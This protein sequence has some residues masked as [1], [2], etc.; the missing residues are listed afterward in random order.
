[1]PVRKSSAVWEGNLARGK[2]TV[3]LGSGL[4]KGSYSFPSRFES[5]EGTNPEELIGAALAGCY[6]M[7]LAHDLSQAGHVPD[8]V[9]TTATVYL[10]RVG[11]AFGI[12]RIELRTEAVV[13]GLDL[14]TFERQ[15]QATKTGCPVGR[16]LASVEIVVKASLQ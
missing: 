10:E 8:S 12:T 15:A 9:S 16:A 1:M 7:A 11:E 3:T 4:F 5:G 14:A 2:G 13:P 6:S